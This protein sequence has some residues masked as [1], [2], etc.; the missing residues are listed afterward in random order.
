MIQNKLNEHCYEHRLKYLSSVWEMALFFK[1]FGS[2]RFKEAG[3]KKP[4][5][6]LSGIC[7]GVAISYGSGGIGRKSISAV[8]KSFLSFLRYR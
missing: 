1:V 2:C 7:K 8:A 3:H 5:K 4:K 6:L